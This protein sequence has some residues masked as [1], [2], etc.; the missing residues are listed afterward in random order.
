[1]NHVARHAGCALLMLAAAPAQAA[2]PPGA[3]YDDAI[4]CAAADMVMAGMLDTPGATAQDRA[5]VAQHKALSALWLDDAT[6]LVKD[7]RKVLSD[8]EAKGASLMSRLQAAR[9]EQDI[10]KAI[11]AARDG[12]AA[13]EQAYAKRPG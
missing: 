13:F 11:E 3:G 12:C 4:R 7:K 5:I 10:T 6:K 8:L 2:L 9:S 1:M